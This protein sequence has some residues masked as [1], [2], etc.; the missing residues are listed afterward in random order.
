MGSLGAF[1]SGTSLLVLPTCLPHRLNS[2][3]E[4]TMSVG[5][6]AVS[7]ICIS[8]VVKCSPFTAPGLIFKVFFTAT[9]PRIFKYVLR[10]HSSTQWHSPFYPQ[11]GKH[12]TRMQ[13]FNTMSLSSKHS[14]K[15]VSE[16]GFFHTGTTFN[17][18]LC[19]LH[20]KRIPQKRTN[21]K[22]GCLLQKT[23][24]SFRASTLASQLPTGRKWA[25]LHNIRDYRPNVFLYNI[26]KEHNLF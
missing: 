11:F 8:S 2:L 5:L 14:A 10:Q 15:S 12:V 13:S 3:P 4:A 7:T 23:K 21:V 1:L 24:F 22:K 26:Q 17:I 6:N 9:S 19:L 20:I 18:T 16:A 25:V